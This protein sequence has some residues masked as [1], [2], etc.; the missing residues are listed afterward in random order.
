MAR[1]HRMRQFAAA[2][3]AAVFATS[4]VACSPDP[5][6]DLDL[7][8]QVGA[9]LPDDAQAQLQSAVDRAVAASGA[10][11]AVVGVWAPWAGTW[12]AG[13]GAVAPEG[14]ATPTSAAFSAANV[15]RAM[16]C[17]V[18]YGLVS[19]GVVHLDDRVGDFVSGIP[20]HEEVTLGQLCDSTSGIASYGP[21]LAGRFAAA[22]D[23]QWKPRELLSFGTGVS[24]A[25]T[26]GAVFSDSDTG[27]VLLGIALE[28]ASHRSADVL[29]DEF[30][31]RPSGM[32]GSSL[33]T[34]PASDIAGLWTPNGEDGNPAC[35]APVEVG[36]LSPT[37]GFT[38]SGVVS[39]VQDLGRYAQA[40]AMGARS[41]DATG[42]FDAPLPATPDAPSWFTAKGGAYQAG[43]LVGQYG[44]TLGH[45][46]AAFADRNT[47][48]TVVVTL[49]N[50]RGSDVIVR[51]LAWQLAA[52]ASKL[53]AAS[54][55]TAPEAGLP[56]TAEDMGGQV[57]AAAV[58]PLP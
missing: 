25:S 2:V 35:A 32:S 33:T 6:V 48:M 52:I 21:V 24:G 38:A 1:P 12:V 39:D 4:L 36:P 11:G 8:T 43:S 29:L 53:P 56:W 34:T 14:A 19:E 20:G 41:Y 45:Q 50:S 18:L 9:S 10:S 49:N 23:R 31:F 16:T 58:C 15:T 40:L 55:Q 30:V 27:Y 7:P 22:P 5:S 28:R 57:A 46:V 47:G 13:T 44:A 37:A 26:P 54:G 42:R 17:D 3:F 51:S